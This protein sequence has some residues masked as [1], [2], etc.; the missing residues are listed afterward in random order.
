MREPMVTVL[1]I[2][3]NG[4]LWAF[5]IGLSVRAVARW[6]R[7][8]RIESYSQADLMPAW[9]RSRLMGE[10]RPDDTSGPITVWGWVVIVV[11]VG[12]LLIKAIRL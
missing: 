11:V 4:L 8:G 7:R 2:I 6:I 9:L 5:I 10:S 1:A 12:W 3:V